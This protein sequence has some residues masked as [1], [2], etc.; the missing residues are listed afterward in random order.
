MSKS[1]DTATKVLYAAMQILQENG[2]E[3]LGSEI[4]RELP[5]KVELTGW[6]KERY[7]KTGYI[8]WESILH[9]HTIGAIKAGYL[10]KKKGIWIL[11]DEGEQ[12]LKSSSPLSFMNE[13]KEA[14]ANWKKDNKALA[15]NDSNDPENS[16]FAVQSDEGSEIQIDKIES[17]A[18]LG[19]KEHISGKSPYEF[20]DMV[21]ALLRA[22]GY[23]TPFVSPKGKDGGVDIIAYNDPLGTK[24]PRIKV[25]VKHRPDAVIS[26]DDVRSL[27]GLL[28]KDDDVA[29][30]VC[31]GRYS[32]EAE[33]LSRD[34][35]KHVELIDGE[36][37]MELWR[38]YYNKMTDEDKS[39]L[40]LYPIY[41][42][43]V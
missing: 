11:T 38:E 16:G 7:E 17:E 43:G 36:R 27:V 28:S 33:R 22:M 41:F 10:R 37:F 19:I 35:H 14:Y 32:T 2:G 31:S 24:T 23:F 5:K 30:F 8:R 9:F 3:M 26:V 12:S 20:Q 29:I 6:E 13:T 1:K 15:D 40:P 21:A 39:M 18:L 42:L 34:S 25:Q 4:I